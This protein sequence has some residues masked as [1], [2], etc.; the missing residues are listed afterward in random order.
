[1]SVKPIPDGYHSI[2]P[3]L[4]VDDGKAAIDFYTRAFGAKEKFRL[5][6]GDRIGHAE[7]EIGDSVV[8]LADEFPD[9]GH[10]GPKSRGGTTVS[11]LHYVEDVDSAFRK[12]I[13]A[14]GTETRPVENQFWGDRMGT[15]T[16]P[17]GHVWSLATTVEAVA[18]DELQRRMESFSK[19]EKQSETA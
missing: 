11:L 3:Y 12:A 4:I 15:L 18:P 10:L 14:G 19:G 17:F 16:D 6:M 1:M 8:M 13:D 2:T 7:L 5:P 9:M